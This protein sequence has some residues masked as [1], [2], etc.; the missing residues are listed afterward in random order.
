MTTAK[1]SQFEVAGLAFIGYTLWVLADTSIKLAGASSLPAP[2]LAA[3]LGLTMTLLLG[4][5]AAVRGNLR[6]LRPRR[7]GRQVLRSLL[8]VANTLGVVVALRHLPLP[9][10]YLLVFLSPFVTSLLAAAWLGERLG[11]RQGLA[12]VV[13]FAGVVVAV[14]PFAPARSG[15]WVGYLAC[16]VCVLA[17]STNMVWSRVIAQTETPQSLTFVSAVVT[18][19]AGAAG[20]LGHV[21]PVSLH[22]AAVLVAT[23]VFGVAG[24]L[25]FFAALKHASAAGVAQYHYTQLITGSLLAY[26]I[27]HESLTRPML[28]GG[29]LIVGAGVFTATR[30]SSE[31]P[32]DRVDRL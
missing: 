31:V 5:L 16:L 2:E 26:A 15:D 10:F 22:L 23:G 13:G 20:S 12:I 8:D 6:A 4:L 29:V 28:A 30:P 19:L 24:S 7:L 25:C 3:G 21:Q 9:M 27:W 1:L 14:Q 18:L 11:A 17:F 32:Q